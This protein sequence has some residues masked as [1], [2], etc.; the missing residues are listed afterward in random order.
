MPLG[1]DVCLLVATEV[2]LRHAENDPTETAAAITTVLQEKS[3]AVEST[4][5]GA[6]GNVFNVAGQTAPRDGFK[7]KTGDPRK[8]PSRARNGRAASVQNQFGSSRAVTAANFRNEKS[9]SNDFKWHN[10][11]RLC[12]NYGKDPRC[13]DGKHLDRDCPA[14]RGRAGRTLICADASVP[15]D[16]P[17]FVDNTEDILSHHEIPHRTPYIN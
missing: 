13:L 3:L 10:E 11:R 17:G 15:I 12:V 5:P 4:Q 7:R 6:C 1:S 2:K 14:N 8:A 9:S 16:P